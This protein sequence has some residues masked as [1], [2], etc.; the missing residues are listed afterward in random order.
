MLE[1]FATSE[2]IPTCLV[3][4]PDSL[5]KHLH[6]L[7]VTTSELPFTLGRYLHRFFFGVGCATALSVLIPSQNTD[8]MAALKFVRSV[9]HGK[10]N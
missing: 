4:T 8:V 7:Q 3:E 10:K 9:C 6:K 1:A 5:S 2:A